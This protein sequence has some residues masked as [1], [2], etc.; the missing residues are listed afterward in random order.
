MTWDYFLKLKKGEEILSIKN[1]NMATAR[2]LYVD[3][4]EYLRQKEENENGGELDCPVLF[5]PIT[6]ET[7]ASETAISV[8]KFGQKGDIVGMDF[9]SA[10]ALVEWFKKRKTHPLTNRPI[11]LNP[12]E[13]R[14]QYAVRLASFGPFEITS[15]RIK[16]L[17]PIFLNDCMTFSQTY[18]KEYAWMQRKLKMGDTGIHMTFEGTAY[19]QRT[20][21]MAYLADKPT[22]TGVFRMSSIESTKLVECFAISYVASAQKIA[23]T[24]EGQVA[25]ISET[26]IRN[27]AVAHIMG[28]GYTIMDAGVGQKLPDMDNGVSNGVSLPIHNMMWASLLDLLVYLHTDGYNFDLR[29]MVI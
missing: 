19:E 4:R 29:Y 16:E 28:Y 25:V 11:D 12:L 10:D 20:A 21:A 14:A 3:N 9:V 27:V 8:A 1:T 15:E 18:P 22:G 6:T 26:K 23:T 5:T 7:V 13:K 24:S 17:F 2:Q